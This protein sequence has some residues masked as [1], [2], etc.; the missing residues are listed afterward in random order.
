MV[1]RTIA[2]LLL[3]P[4]ILTSSF[5]IY[6]EI[7]AG[8]SVQSLTTDA[9]GKIV[10]HKRDGGSTAVLNDDGNGK[11]AIP[12]GSFTPTADVDIRGTLYVG[13]AV[14]DTFSDAP[15]AV[16]RSPEHS[17]TLDLFRQSA[18]AGWGLNV[19]N[20]ATGNFEINKV[21]EGS[22][23]TK[24]TVKNNGDLDIANDLFVNAGFAEISQ[25]L[26]MS[27]G[28]VCGN[29]SSPCITT[30]TGTDTGIYWPGSG[31]VGVSGGGNIGVLVKSNGD[32]ELNVG[33]DGDCG[34]GNVCSYD[35]QS[36]A[37]LY[38]GIE[39]V[40]GTPGD[41]GVQAVRIGNIVSITGKGTAD[42]TASARTRIGI[43][44]TQLPSAFHPSTNFV[45]NEDEGG[46]PP[47]LSE[48]R[49]AE[50][51]GSLLKRSTRA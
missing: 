50:H 23:G 18:A 2:W 8:S 47:A 38:F 10:A 7:D 12:V 4:I 3:T 43:D 37:S 40:S 41:F 14:P 25:N 1:I 31:E 27:N 20:S 48:M 39:N 51:A 21:G 28:D 16:R 32:A 45:A 24:L 30:K 36:V 11:F 9:S 6:E 19:T 42:P 29:N 46:G 49:K 26:R 34:I 17:S 44:L 35:A 15:M 13:G 22:T 33:T 5:L